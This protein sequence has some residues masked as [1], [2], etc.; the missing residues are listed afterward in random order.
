MES[1]PSTSDGSQAIPG[2]DWDSCMHMARLLKRPPD[3]TLAVA[4]I[5]FKVYRDIAS[6]DNLSLDTA[7]PAVRFYAG[8]D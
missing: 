5:L 8:W 1:E 4:E 3:A 2:P 7:Q 6:F